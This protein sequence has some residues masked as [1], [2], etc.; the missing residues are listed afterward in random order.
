[1]RGIYR[2]GLS[3][4]R[5]QVQRNVREALQEGR[6]IQE[7]H[8]RGLPRKLRRELS[9]LEEALGRPIDCLDDVHH[10]ERD[11]EA[12]RH[13]VAVAGTFVE[14]ARELAPERRR[15][16]VLR[17]MAMLLLVAPFG[18]VLS[19]RG[20]EL[21]EQ[22]DR[23]HVPSS[24]NF[25]ALFTQ[26]VSRCVQTDNEQCETLCSESG[27]CA[28]SSGK[29]VAQ[30]RQHCEQSTVC[31]LLGQCTPFQGR[32]IAAT[33]QDCATSHACRSSGLCKITNPRRNPKADEP[34]GRCIA[35]SDLDC[36]ASD[37]CAS[38]S[39][40]AAVN[41]RCHERVKK[42]CAYADVCSSEGRCQ[43]TFDGRCIA[44]A[45]DHCR[46]SDACMVDG[47]CMARDGRCQALANW[48][49][50]GSQRCRDEGRCFAALEGHCVALQDE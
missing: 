19:V 23:T 43:S 25:A 13:A 44:T 16:K 1:M 6:A 49:C 12:Y 40:C 41:G 35:A 14:G 26:R 46:Y 15:R 32:C 7:A 30:N 2:D 18:L 5:E 48:G 34:H 20:V 33:D 50:A 31:Q 42:S 17:L 9:R 21:V 22:C 38:K 28:V 39:K 3:Q 10:R 47:R 45:D 27:L 24:P 36:A 8:R 37:V 29:C 4:T 11:I